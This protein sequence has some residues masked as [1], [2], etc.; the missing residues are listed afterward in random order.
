MNLKEIF[1]KQRLYFKED[2]TLD[3]N[4]RIKNLNKLKNVIKENEENIFQALEKDLGKSNFEAYATEVSFVYEEINHF[5]KNLKK[6]TRPQRVRT[7]IV[8]FPSKGKILYQPLGQTLIISPWNYPFQLAMVPLVGAIGAGNTA[9][10]KPSRNSK[11]TTKILQKIINNNFSSELIYVV[12]PFEIDNEELTK[13]KFDH[14]FFTGST[15]GGREINKAFTDNL[16]KVTLELGGKSPCIVDKTSDVDLAAKRI[17][18]GKFLNSGQTCVAPDYILANES[19]EEELL[20]SITKWIEEFY[21]LNPIE[22]PDYGK[23]INDKS[24]NRLQG[25]IKGDI[26]YEASRDSEKLKMG[27]VIIK[28]VNFDDEIMQEEIFGPILPVIKYTDINEVV[29]KLKTLDKPLAFYVFTKDKKV[30]NLLTTSLNFGG[31]TINDVIVHLASNKL[32][33]GGVGQ[34]GIGSY[35]GKASMDCFSH[36]KSIMKRYF[37]LDVNIKYPPYEGKLGL[38]KKIMK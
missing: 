14:V 22:S 17:V 10:I 16:A 15:S 21:G 29:E 8:Q 20:K 36:K 6:W 31:A 13:H 7:P 37:A 25:L 30:E 33:F 18:W 28:G 9:I 3:V 19:I 5:I 34:S 11:E 23:I 2:K 38:I 12:N 26:F 27:P 24:Y 35:H 4:F 1:D 32:P